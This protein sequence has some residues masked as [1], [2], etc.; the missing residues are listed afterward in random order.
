MRHM[1]RSVKLGRNASHRTA[2]L[3]NMAVSLILSASEGQSLRRSGRIT[4]TVHKA[5]FLR[6]FVEKLVTLSKRAALAIA[7][8][9]EVPVRGTPSWVEWRHSPAWFDW[10]R[11]VAPAVA[12]RR[13]AF[14]RLR[15][16]EATSVL[17]DKLAPRFASRQGGYIRVVRFADYRIGDSGRKA[18]VEFVGE[19]D[20]RSR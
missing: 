12:L 19:H 15:S 2:M 20:S 6:P 7:N 4:T 11:I 5:K 16:D 10:A 1:R 17:F 13:R 18:F 9:P 14:S 3:R 8:A